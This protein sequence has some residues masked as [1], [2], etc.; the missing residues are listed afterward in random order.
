MAAAPT[1]APPPAAKPRF[2][3][4][5]IE[6]ILALFG[7]VRPGEGTTVVLL[8]VNV[9]LVLSAY[10][11]LKVA[12]E[13]LILL[14][15][16][17]A[18]KSYASVGQSILLVFVAS[19][20]G[21]LAAR[22]GRL[23]L[24]SSVSLFFI[25]NLVVFIALGRV[26][27]SLG[28][29]FFLWVGIFNVVTIAQ[30]WSFAADVYSEEQGKRLFAIVGIG[31]ATGAVAGAALAAPLIHV[32]SPFTLMA[33]AAV[34]LLVALGFTTIVHR[35]ETRRTRAHQ[36][37]A[38][39]LE[40]GAAFALV[41]RDRY[42]LTFALLVLALNFVTKSGDYAL[43]SMLLA[44]S[45]AH[46]GALGV[47]QSVYIGQF[48]AHYFQLINV[49]GVV[50]QLFLVSR[51][52][53]YVGLRAVLV[54]I[55]LASTVG[56][57]ATL[58]LP[59][60]EVLFVARIIESSLDYSLSNTSQ[61]TLWL[62]TTREAKYKAKQVIDTFFKRAGDTMSAAVV[63]LTVHFAL[64]TRSFLAINVALSLAWLGLA[65]ALG[66]G[67]MRRS[68]PPAARAEQVVVANARARAV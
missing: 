36:A 14:G 28:I 26:G 65:I 33:V 6:F 61:Q 18:V 45:E 57:G 34:L 2:R 48:K 49:T 68:A 39:P 23:V 66:R 19:A 8:T 20:Y 38:E 62:V 55:P 37:V 29:P 5:P 15:G 50:M 58:L 53:K 16:G 27:V 56:Y 1:E 12:R 64:S 47:A 59:M 32:G 25:G 13:P 21:W 46:A 30:F 35:R 7:E 43:D 51:I 3:E 22:V 40:R 63:W 11:L 67:Y 31:S 54:L 52:V 10:Y 24:V 4:H 44:Q 60:I 42:L 9:F 41:L 17:A